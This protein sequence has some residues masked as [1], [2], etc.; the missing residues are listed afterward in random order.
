MRNKFCEVFHER[1]LIVVKGLFR[2][3][4]RMRRNKRQ[5]SLTSGM[6]GKEITASAINNRDAHISALARDHESENHSKTYCVFSN[7][8]PPGSVTRGASGPSI[9]TNFLIGCSCKRKNLKPTSRGFPD[10]SL[11]AKSLVDRAI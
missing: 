4:R 11:A 1:Y 5:H 8:P 10:L 7:S 2:Y 6:R 3:G 9:S